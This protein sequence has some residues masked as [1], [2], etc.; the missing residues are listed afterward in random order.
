MLVFS[1]KSPLNDS[2]GTDGPGIRHHYRQTV[3]DRKLS[4]RLPP[5][6]IGDDEK[7]SI[8]GLI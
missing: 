4:T 7:L 5:P 8:Y 1:E 2:S 6:F 3:S